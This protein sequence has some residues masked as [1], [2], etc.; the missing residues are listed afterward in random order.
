MKVSYMSTRGVEYARAYAD[1]FSVPENK[2]LFYY[3]TAGVDCT[4]F[5]SQCVWA[6][7]GGWMP[8]MDG[9]TI[10]RNKERMN[11]HLGMVPFVW[12]GSSYYVGS[13]K[14]CRV[15]EFYAFSISP[16]GSGPMAAPLFEGTWE[17][18]DPSILKEGDV[19]QLVVKSYVPTRFGH[20]LY[21]TQAGNT[22]S[23]V[24]VCCHSYD[25]LDGPLTEFS[26]FPAEYT[27]L[28]V[29]RFTEADLNF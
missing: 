1:Y 27:R 16:K 29:L 18:L 3:D 19:L 21:I 6:A 13:N 17:T 5:I 25:R 9:K 2:R 8:G 26:S 12:Y 20:S 15:M 11:A 24:L 7:Y 4:N 10:A 28:R 22:L 23:E 14:W